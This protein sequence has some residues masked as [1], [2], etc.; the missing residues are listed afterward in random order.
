MTD[1]A[2]IGEERQ[3]TSDLELDQIIP[4]NRFNELAC[5]FILLVLKICYHPFHFSSVRVSGL[6]LIVGIGGFDSSSSGREHP[7]RDM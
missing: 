6:V 1:I 3:T 7:P 5:T 2:Y 4:C